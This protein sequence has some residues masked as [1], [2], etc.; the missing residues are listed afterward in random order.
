MATSFDQLVQ[1]VRS[2]L[3]GFTKDQEQYSSLAT[4]M[5][6]TD[7]S[8]NVDTATVNNLGSGTAEIGTE[9]LLVKSV[10]RTTGTVLVLGNL[11]GRGREGT[12]AASHNVD[13]LVT[14]SPAFPRIRMQ[15][16]VNDTI[17]GVYPTLVTFASTEIV[18]AMPQYEY[19]MPADAK[20]VWQVHGSTIGPSK[21]WLVL[22]NWR[23]NE[24]ANT[25]AF[26]TGKSIQLL[27]DI[28][29]GQTYRIRYSKPPSVLV[30]PGDDFA[31]TTGLP[32]RCV[33]LI[34]FGACARLLPSYEAGRLQQRAIESSERA[35]TVPAL[36]A[37]KAAQYFM[38]LY[39]QRLEEERE[40]QIAENPMVQYFNGM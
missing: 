22:Q 12:T 39:Q 17:L 33:D 5:T 35:Q 36:S 24:D 19:G 2:M 1:R 34:V 23:F 27:D 6:A 7:T 31:T 11:S 28:T 29:S 16:A 14:M 10:D 26:P 25:T 38:G 3:L 30:N 40:R 37:A 18:K 20:D 9:L 32:D 15:E 4:S 13:D 8:F 21:Q